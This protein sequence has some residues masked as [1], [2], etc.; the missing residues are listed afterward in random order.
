M[1]VV[2]FCGGL[3]MRM[4]EY[5]EAIPKPMVPIGSRPMLWHIM[6]YYAH[7]G[8]KDYILCLGHKGNSIKDYFLKYDECVSNDFVY[9]KGGR[10]LELLTSDI[11]DWTI[12]F[13]DTGLHTNIGQRLSAVRKHVEDD[14]IFLANYSDCLSDLNLAAMLEHFRRLGKIAAFIAVKPNATFHLIE[15]DTD[16]LVSD[17]RHVNES[18]Q[19]INGGFFAFRREIFNY[20]QNGEDLVQEPFRRLIAERQLMAYHY[21]GFWACMDTVKEVQQLEDLYSQGKA[22]WQVWRCGMATETCSD[23]QV[24]NPVRQGTR[25]YNLEP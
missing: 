7:F 8:H 5:P 17:I 20:L 13:A 19:R 24:Q 9:S 10:N 12:T 16:G 4:R 23:Q 18:K 25:G 15:A 1:K 22:P 21:E 6:K 11:Q 3:G 2:L 14:E